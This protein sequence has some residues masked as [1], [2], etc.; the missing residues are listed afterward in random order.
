MGHLVSHCKGTKQQSLGRPPTPNS[1]V[2]VPTYGLGQVILHQNFLS[3]D[4]VKAAL[5]V[6]TE[7]PELRGATRAVSPT[8][9]DGYGPRS[10]AEGPQVQVPVTEG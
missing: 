2:S 5:A 3:W 1:G 6:V 8:R 10:L 4:G 7:D 9:R